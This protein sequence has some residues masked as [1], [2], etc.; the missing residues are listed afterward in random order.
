M[1]QVVNDSRHLPSLNS[2][3]RELFKLLLFALTTGE[4]S[5][6]PD[7]RR[8]QESTHL[9]QAAAVRLYFINS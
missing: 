3:L 6:Q 4:G 2:L 7:R 8:L 1:P 5:K 9:F